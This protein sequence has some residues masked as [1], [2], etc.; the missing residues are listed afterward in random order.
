MFRHQS[1]ACE[2][3]AR[4]AATPER[5]ACMSVEEVRFVIPLKISG[6]TRFVNPRSGTARK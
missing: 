4:T 6:W 2:E 5:A 3:D 1:Q